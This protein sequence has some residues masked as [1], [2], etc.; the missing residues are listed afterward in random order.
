MPVN[1]KDEF[2]EALLD[3][4]DSIRK[5]VKFFTV[6]MIISLVLAFIGAIIGLFAWPFTL[7]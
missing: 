5:M 2:S 6:L 1:N 4:I 7:I 3:K